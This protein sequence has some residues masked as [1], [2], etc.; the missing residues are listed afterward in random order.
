MVFWGTTA[1]EQGLL[2]SALLRRE[3]GLSSEQ[4]RGGHQHRR[5]AHLRGHPRL[6]HRRIRELPAG[7]LRRPGQRAHRPG[8][9][10][11]PGAGEGILLSARTT[12]PWRSRVC[13]PT[14]GAPATTTSSMVRSGAG[15]NPTPGRPTTTTRS[16][17]STP[18]TGTWAAP[19]RTSPSGSA[20]GW[21]WPTPTPSPS[22]TKARSSKPFVTP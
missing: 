16:P 2:G 4:D 6:R 15:P 21:S 7:R 1:E 8:G 10:T 18:R 14:T 17:T 20:S 3:P 11:E 12:S 9:E 5:P 22:G 19:C 13:R